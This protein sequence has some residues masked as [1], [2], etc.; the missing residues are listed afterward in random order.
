MKK[1]ILAKIGLSLLVCTSLCTQTISMQV[2]QGGPKQVGEEN[3][4]LLRI[5]KQL[6]EISNIL[7]KILSYDG[8]KNNPEAKLSNLIAPGN[9]KV[10][11]P[12]NKTT[13]DNI[14]GV[15]YRFIK[16]P[17]A[18][19]L[20]PSEI[21]KLQLLLKAIADDATDI[22]K[23]NFYTGL[24]ER[25]WDR[26]Y[27]IIKIPPED[28]KNIISLLK[29]VIT[30]ASQMPQGNL[31][32]IPV[33]LQIPNAQLALRQSLEEINKI[34]KGKDVLGPQ[35]PSIPTIG[36]ANLEKLILLNP[37][38]NNT[39]KEMENER[40]NIRQTLSKSSAS[41]LT[42]ELED[43]ENIKLLR[44]SIMD[45]TKPICS[46]SATQY[47]QNKIVTKD[48]PDEAKE[49]LQNEFT[50]INSILK[51]PG[52]YG[53]LNKEQNF[54]SI[55]NSNDID[56]LGTCIK[57]E[58]KFRVGVIDHFITLKKTL[59]EML[60]VPNPINFLPIYRSKPSLVEWHNSIEA[61]LTVANN[62]NDKPFLRDLFSEL[63]QLKMSLE[64][65]STVPFKQSTIGAVTGLVSNKIIPEYFQTLPI[66]WEDVPEKLKR[67][68]NEI[69]HM[70]SSILCD[71]YKTE[72][73]QALTNQLENK[74]QFDDH[75][76]QNLVEKTDEIWILS[77]AGGGIRGKIAAEILKDISQQTK[78]RIVDKFDFFAG[79]SVGGLIVTSLNIPQSNL[80]SN[81]TVSP[82]FNED[83]VAGLL[84]EKTAKLIFPPLGG[85]EKK[86]KQG[87]WYAYDEYS[88]E[89]LLISNFDYDLFSDMI[90]PTIVMVTSPAKKGSLRLR[91]YGK[92]CSKIFAWQAARAT[93][94][95]PS[96]FP[97]MAIFYNNELF[98]VSD[99][100]VTENNPT[101]AAISE[102]RNLFNVHHK[103]LPKQINIVFIGTSKVPHKEGYVMH[104]VGAQGLA[105]AF[106]AAME[107]TNSATETQV[108][109]DIEL[110]R[111]WGIA[112][113]F[114]DINPLVKEAIELD[115][116]SPDNLKLLVDAAQSVMHNP[117]YKMLIDHLMGQSPEGSHDIIISGSGKQG[118]I[119]EKWEFERSKLK[120]TKSFSG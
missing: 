74:K 24:A 5:K 43:L 91:S 62:V 57:L 29:D 84:E 67:A 18:G 12:E 77:L 55:L 26:S 60:K 112:V 106:E 4:P 34:L 47:V 107:K 64:S 81:L 98:E 78:A 41:M 68:I 2:E 94:A 110:L 87:T 58:G 1:V 120:R 97:P 32:E 30:T 86:R 27:I 63:T 101:H 9:Y 59:S 17:K 79:T 25:N 45:H 39:D 50:K 114:Y 22:H 108:T 33:T 73:M 117:G 56:I 37:G 42:F 40:F 88:I 102:V 52:E 82:L 44:K 16:N 100:G 14:K 111:S 61:K 48:I 99:G 119:I 95:A 23:L 35:D 11:G 109:S 92:E 76:I 96:Y 54:S 53:I 72:P 49:A 75:K 83:F 103:K 116:S 36:G 118:A 8:E 15:L 85:F 20:N 6:D 71:L 38:C 19:R 21:D 105:Q 46:S 89:N 70:R 13:R 66:K 93:S 80:V 115:D 28:K 10:Y 104:E 7:I 113:N 51:M 90:K 65:F 31:E 69:E 3:D